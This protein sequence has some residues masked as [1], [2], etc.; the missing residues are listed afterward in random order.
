MP[1]LPLE[2]IT[3]DARL[4]VCRLAP[5]QPIPAWAAEEKGFLS[6]TLTAEELSLVCPE[7]RVPAGVRAERGFRALKIRGPLDFNL[8]GVLSSLLLPLAQRGISVFA[9]STYDTDY[10]LVREERLEEAL[11]LLSFEPGASSR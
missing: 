6:L 9:L 5:G 10:L 7:A 1:N 4:A 3:L 11:A 2:L 8:T